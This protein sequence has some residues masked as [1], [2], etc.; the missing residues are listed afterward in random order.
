MKRFSII[1]NLIVIVAM[2]M[3]FSSCKSGGQELAVITAVTG[4]I[5]VLKAGTQTPVAGQTGMKIQV[6]DTVKAGANS[7]GVITFFDGSTVELEP[8]TRIEITTLDKGE[9]GAVTILLKQTLGE[10]ISRVTKLADPKSRYE[11]ETVAATAAVR[12]S[13]MVVYV[14]SN[15]ITSVGNEEGAISVI[16]ANVEVHVPEGQHSTVIPGETPGEPEPGSRPVVITTAIFPDTTGDLFDGSSKRV[17]G[18]YYID[19]VSSQASW[20]GGYFTVHLELKSPCPIKTDDASTFI[21]WDVLIDADANASTGFSWPLI[22]NDIG[23]EYLVR[24]GLSGNEYWG[25]VLTVSTDTSVDIEYIVAIY[26]YEEA[27]NILELYF[28][29]ELIGSPEKFNWITAVRQYLA[30]N[31]PNLP[32]VSD[33]SPNEGYYTFP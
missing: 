10:T 18:K 14:A 7:T 26:N 24:V 3:V 2:T 23:Y 16:A 25:E 19:I 32:S 28:P 15:G 5:L 22:G 11:I 33:K 6:G 8:D 12:G 4:D 31:P 29:E 30:D 1:V 17:T 20:T 9:A 13:T 21:E 27:G